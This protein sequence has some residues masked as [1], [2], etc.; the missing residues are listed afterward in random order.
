MERGKT[1]LSDILEPGRVELLHMDL[2]S[3]A[4]VRAGAKEFLERNKGRGLDVLICNAGVMAI[5]TLTRNTD[6]FETQFGTNHLAHFLLFNLL[7]PALLAASTPSFSSRV[8][9]VSSS[10]HRGGPPRFADY[11][12]EKHP[13][14][15]SPFGGYASSKCANVYTANYIDRHYGPQGIHA[16]SLH[17]GGI[18]T[19]LQKHIDPEMLKGWK[20]HPK[21]EK[22]IKRT[23]QGAATTVWAA[24]AKQ[25]EGTG[26][27]YLEDCQVAQQIKENA[28]PQDGGHA[29]HAYNEEGEERLWRDSLGMVGLEA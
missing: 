7:K 26:G 5:P 19:P 24:V 2:S 27:K 13:D 9:M 14:E 15:Y 6:G 17:P 21:V 3:L 10:G 8:V 20:S 1:A 29:P 22:I 28:T 25:W 4:S 11:N 18:W 16:T 23:E 12:Y